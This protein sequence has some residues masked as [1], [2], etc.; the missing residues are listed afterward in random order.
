[1]WVLLARARCEPP[2][3]ECLEGKLL[4]AP[5]GREAQVGEVRVGLLREVW[6]MESRLRPIPL[7]KDPTY[8]QSARSSVGLGIHFRRTSEEYVALAYR[9]S[10]IANDRYIYSESLYRLR[11]GTFEPVRQERFF[12][13]VAGLEGLDWRVFWPLNFACPAAC[14]AIGAFMRKRTRKPP[15]SFATAG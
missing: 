6:S 4:L 11:A 1:M 14:V 15:V 8:Q 2:T 10:E 5:H 3:N 9:T 7:P 12:Y 13:D